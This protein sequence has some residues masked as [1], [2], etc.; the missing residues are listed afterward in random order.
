MKLLNTASFDYAVDS[1]S[2][3]ISLDTA[4]EYVAELSDYNFHGYALLV[5]ARY[6]ENE[7][8]ISGLE[9]VN[10]QHELIGG[11]APYLKKV[12]DD[13]AMILK[14]QNPKEWNALSV[15]L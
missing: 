7:L 11:L 14:H 5:I 3:Y 1:D 8:A 10:K 4:L 2:S 6:A 9:M 15:N 13:I 12:R